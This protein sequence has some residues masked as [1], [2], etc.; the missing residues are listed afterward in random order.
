MRFTSVTLLLATSSALQLQGTPKSRAPG[1][2][3]AQPV[4][5]GAKAAAAFGTASALLLPGAASAA[6]DASG[7][8]ALPALPTLP[9][10]ATSKEAH[11]LGV[12]LAQTVISWGVPAAAIGGLALLIGPFGGKPQDGPRP[13]PPALAKGA[14]A[15]NTASAI[16]LPNMV[17]VRLASEQPWA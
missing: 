15:S 7:G 5:L 4:P 12:Y 16:T 17:C 14:R 2:S 11:D 10:W 1:A 6:E 13:L 8:W 9:D 3:S